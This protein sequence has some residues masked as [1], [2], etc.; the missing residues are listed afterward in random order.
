[1][2]LDQVVNQSFLL[3][4]AG[5]AIDRSLLCLDNIVWHLLPSSN[6]VPDDLLIEPDSLSELLAFLEVLRY[7]HFLG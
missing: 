1:M 7:L 6:W 5:Q 3:V 2:K 4:D